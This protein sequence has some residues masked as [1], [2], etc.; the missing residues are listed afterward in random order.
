[1]IFGVVIFVNVWSAQKWFLMKAF[2]IR[3]EQTIASL[4]FD[5]AKSTFRGHF[6]LPNAFR[7][8]HLLPCDVEVC[9]II[10]SATCKTGSSAAL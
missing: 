7:L 9:A 4:S 3:L 6:V 8:R 10:V 5:I 1:M 2:V